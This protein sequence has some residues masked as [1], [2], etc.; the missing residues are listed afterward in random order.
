MKKACINCHF[1]AKEHVD[2]KGEIRNFCLSQKEREEI[3]E[4]DNYSK[5]DDFT[6]PCYKGVWRHNENNLYH[7]VV[8]QKRHNCFFYPTQKSMQYFAASELQ[9]REQEVKQMRRSNLYTMIAL[10]IASAG[11]FLN[12]FIELFK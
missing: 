2:H 11:L 3:K 7:V 1:F 12:I 5:V 9:K 10:I 8:K 6:L 4:T